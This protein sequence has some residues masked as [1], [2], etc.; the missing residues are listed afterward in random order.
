M[1][2]KL[3]ARERFVL[4]GIAFAG[5]SSILLDSTGLVDLAKA[6]EASPGIPIRLEGFVDATEN[7]SEDTQASMAM[8]M[9][10][11]RRLAVF[12]IGRE[13]VSVDA[14]GGEAPLLPNF[15]TKGRT[16]NRRLEV[17]PLAGE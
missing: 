12:G 16:A 17:V 11:T 13:R 3:G 14:R 6:M 4:E 5:R 2:R 8:V 1:A 15:T 7:A 10:A 9:A